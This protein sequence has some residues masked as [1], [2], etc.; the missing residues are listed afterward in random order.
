[1]SV[2]EH[3]TSE[4]YKYWAFISYSHQDASFARRLHRALETYPIPKKLVE[5]THLYGTLPRRLAPIFLD[6]DELPGSPDLSEQIEAALLASRYLIVIC[7]PASARSRYVHGEIVA[8]KSMGRGSRV[9]AI[10][11]SGEPNSAV[12]GQ[13]CFSE[14]LRLRFDSDG[15]KLESQAE[16]LACDARSK[17][18]GFRNAK[19]KLIA[20]I[21]GVGFDE[22]RQRDAERRIRQQQQLVSVLLL[23]IGVIA[24]LSFDLAIQRNR[25][26]SAEKH[27]KSA[28]A[29]SDMREALRALDSNTANQALVFLSRSARTDPDT[30]RGKRLLI[31]LLTNEAWLVR[32]Y[33][34]LIHHGAVFSARFSPDG[35]PLYGPMVNDSAVTDL[36]CSSDGAC[37]AAICA[38]NA[39]SLWDL[40]TGQQVGNVLHHQ[41]AISVARF[42]PDSRLLATGS[43]DHTV[44]V[45]DLETGLPVE[46]PQILPSRVNALAFSADGSQLAIGEQNGDLVIW[47]FHLH[48]EGS[49]DSLAEL[50]NA[51]ESITRL[52]F[53]QNG[54]VMPIASDSR[55]AQWPPAKPP[56][57][58][59]ERVM[60]WLLDPTEANQPAPF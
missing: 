50:C 55:L 54:I 2:L 40:K 12:Q 21:C 48:L 11:A 17:Q 15:K 30:P 45:W 16:P 53:D 8:F 24:I 29:I 37:L 57:D 36:I 41:S 25:A 32:L 18:D 59:Y 28:L 27:T 42:T 20:G 58:D 10:I 14:A 47:N 4:D 19:L 26:T 56:K 34:D 7:S 23:I 9:L 39:A 46:L 51:V 6:R 49:S 43:W 52:E 22:I 38:D 3:S 33:P 31:S 35:S 44:R 5:R 60:K 13:E 1:M